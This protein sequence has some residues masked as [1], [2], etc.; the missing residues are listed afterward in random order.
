MRYLL[1]THAVIWYFDDSPKL[2]QKVARIIDNPENIVCISSISVWEIA[3]KMN[4]GKLDVDFTL[5]ELLIEIKENNFDILQ[6]EDEYLQGL[7]ALPFIHRDPFD[8]L[9]V[10]TAKTEKITVLTADENVQKYDV[11]CI[12]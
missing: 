10:A 5:D 6:I 1:D 12:W 11:S 7:S 3:I 4:I 8:R 2:S 9:L